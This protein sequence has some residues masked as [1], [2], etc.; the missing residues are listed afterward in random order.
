MKL[1]IHQP[2]DALKGIVKQYV[3]IQSIEDQE[4]LW[5]LPNL[6]NYL[7]FNPGIE[8]VVLGANSDEILHHVPKKFSVGIK[9]TNIIRIIVTEKNSVRFPMYGI[10]LHPTAYHRLFAKNAHELQERHILFEEL[11]HTKNIFNEIYTLDSVS[12]QLHYFEKC[13]LQLKEDAK[14]TQVIVKKWMRLLL[15]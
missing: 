9:F 15:L 11:I 1:A 10:E 4:K 6:G 13:L 14:E 3:E 5:V 8:G 12:E 2:C 7:L